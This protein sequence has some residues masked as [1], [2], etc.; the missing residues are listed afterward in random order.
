M[1]ARN[2]QLTGSRVIKRAPPKKI[3]TSRLPRKA[4]PMVISS[5][6]SISLPVGKPRA[7]REILRLL[8][9]LSCFVNYSMV[10][11][12]AI[13]GLNAKITSRIFPVLTRLSKFLILS[14]SGVLPAMGSITPPK[15]WYTPSYCPIRSIVV[16]SC[17]RATTQITDWLRRDERQI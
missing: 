8:Y 4:S 2:D 3:Q 15:T 16:S 10:V 12:P 13:S 9:V 14:L 7:K 1:A 5:A 17:G 11:S 6:Y